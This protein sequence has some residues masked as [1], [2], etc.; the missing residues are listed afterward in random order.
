MR[1]L[2]SVRSADEVEPA[3]A[4]GADIIDAK[5][6]ANGS[7]GAV[8]AATLKE[9]FSRVAP[10]QDLSV[11]LGDVMSVSQVVAMIDGL[12]LPLRTAPTYL[13]LGFAG[14]KSPDTVRD[15]LRAAVGS[16]GR[17][18]SAVTIVAVAYADSERAAALPAEIILN[19]AAAAGVGGVLID[20][21]I[22]DGT[23]LLDWRTRD[24]LGS[25]VALAR[26]SGLMVGVAGSLRAEDTAAMALAGPDV[27]GFRGAAC[28]AG[29]LG[30]VSMDRVLV[31]RRCVDAVSPGLG[32]RS[33]HNAEPSAKRVI[34]SGIEPLA[35]R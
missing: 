27:I 18:Q 15:L 31:L 16:A 13:K 8:S 26:A 21:H 1:L 14:V 9:V 30:R 11:A 23:R 7:L 5:E 28:D 33:S 4:G 17:H 6:P 19:S 24:T 25:W 3:L 35:P 29:R 10:T 34:E 20:T 22:K 2:V 32:E 12:R